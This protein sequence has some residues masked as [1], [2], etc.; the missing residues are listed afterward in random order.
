MK[1][2]PP[3]DGAGVEL[4][5]KVK[6]KPPV[7]AVKDCDCACG[8]GGKGFGVT[9][10]APLILLGLRILLTIVRTIPIVEQY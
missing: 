7:F 2:K 6:P 1:L 9:G 4:D 8:W 10:R 3:D 5:P